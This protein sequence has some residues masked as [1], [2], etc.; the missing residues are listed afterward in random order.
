VKPRRTNPLVPALT[1]LLALY[2]LLQLLLL[3]HRA[4]GH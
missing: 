1:P 2:L 4:L 3:Q